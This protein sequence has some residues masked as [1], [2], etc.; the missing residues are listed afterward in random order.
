MACI[1]KVLQAGV[2]PAGSR[3]QASR[4]HAELTAIRCARTHVSSVVHRFQ[5]FISESSARV[6]SCYWQ[7]L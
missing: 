2:A 6:S 4:E 7:G 5:E 1:A 3:K